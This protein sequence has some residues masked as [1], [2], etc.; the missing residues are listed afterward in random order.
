[1]RGSIVNTYFSDIPNEQQKLVKGLL[2]SV[3]EKQ[4]KI[5][6]LETKIEEQ[7][8]LVEFATK[9]SDTSSLIDMA[10]MAKLLHDENI[11]I[12]RNKLF[13]WLQLN[14]ILRTNNEPYQQYINSGYFKVKEYTYTTPYGEKIG[15]KTYVTGKEIGRAHV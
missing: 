11:K 13:K 8:P 1:M 5:N 6:T 15:T 2:T 3:E 10:Q 7:K 12:G 9:V 4:K 14:N